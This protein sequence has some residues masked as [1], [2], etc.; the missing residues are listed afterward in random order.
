MIATPDPAGLGIFVAAALVLLL[1]P[2]PAVVYIVARSLDGLSALLTASA[3]AFTAVK[4]LDAAY[5]VY[6]G[7]RRFLERA[8]V[9]DAAPP[10]ARRLRRAFIDGV[11]VAP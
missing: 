2:G 1:T 8:P 6:L 9:P 11:V 3:S 4:Y 5:L 7:L 10:A